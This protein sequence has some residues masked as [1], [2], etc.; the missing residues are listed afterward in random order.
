MDRIV[1]VNED[2]ER[3]LD[4]RS[5]LYLLVAICP[6]EQEAW[7]RSRVEAVGGLRA[8]VLDPMH[9][10]ARVQL[11]GEKLFEYVRASMDNAGVEN[12]P[13]DLLL[14]AMKA[15]IREKDKE[16]AADDE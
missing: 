16:D 15:K 9:L 13:A 12:I 1:I 14:S 8:A 3:T 10:A 5:Q 7:T 6:D 4:I 11:M 2:E